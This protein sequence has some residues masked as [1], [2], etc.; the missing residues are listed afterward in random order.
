MCLPLEHQQ[1]SFVHQ[2]FKG[3]GRARLYFVP[4]LYP[5]HLSWGISSSPSA[6][7]CQVR[8]Y[9]PTGL[10]RYLGQILKLHIQHGGLC[11]F[12]RLTSYENES[13]W[14]CPLIYKCISAFAWRPLFS[15][16]H[17]GKSRHYWQ[18]KW[19][20]IPVPNSVKF[21]KWLTGNFEP[22]CHSLLKFDCLF[23]NLS[24]VVSD[25]CQNSSSSSPFPAGL[26]TL[27]FWVSAGKAGKHEEGMGISNK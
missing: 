4:R 21:S 19:L 2:I 14:H 27:E 16:L 12:Q 23:M 6:Q 1:I 9:Q 26:T 15:R 24:W 17:L 18:R 11:S 8:R 20:C 3:Q 10:G 5:S 25:Q 22:E 7:L 13:N